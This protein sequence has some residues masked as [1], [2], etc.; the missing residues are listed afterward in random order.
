[1]D[2]KMFY[3]SR[4]RLIGF[5]IFIMSMALLFGGLAIFMGTGNL[6]MDWFLFSL[7]ITL[8]IILVPILFLL[9]KKVVA[10][11][12][13]VIVSTKGID[14]IGFTPKVGFIPWEDIEGCFPYSLKGNDMLGFVHRQEDAYI[15]TFSGTNRK[16]LEIN[17][18]SGF[19]AINVALGHLKDPTSFL[20]ALEEQHVNFY[21]DEEY[22]KTP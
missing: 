3:N 13:A 6:E 10:N 1:M 18:N 16:M 12:P 17:K 14:I 21:L 19:P 7:S 9:V 2:K 8:V 5:A 15:N 20:D 22:G 11:K 4:A